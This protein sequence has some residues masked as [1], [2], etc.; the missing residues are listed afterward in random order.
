MANFETD[1]E[2]VLELNLEF[3]AATLNDA[4][5]TARN[6]L[7]RV[8][9]SA[10]AQLMQLVNSTSESLVGQDISGANYRYEYALNFRMGKSDNSTDDDV[11]NTIFAATAADALSALQANAQRITNITNMPLKIIY[12]KAEAPAPSPPPGP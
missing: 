7:N 1:S 2:L 12:L 4:D 10:A 8:L 11:Y 6:F 5:N 3:Y 9:G